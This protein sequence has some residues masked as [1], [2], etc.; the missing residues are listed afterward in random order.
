MSVTLAIG[1]LRYSIEGAPPPPWLQRY[2]VPASPTDRRVQFEVTEDTHPQASTPSGLQGFGYALDS[3]DG[4]DLARI[5]QSGHPAEGFLSA[6]GGIV[7][8]DAPS[9][10]AMV[11]HAGAL[12]IQDGVALVMAPPGT[13]KTTLVRAGGPRAFAHNAVLVRR[14]ESAEMTAWALPFAGDPDPSLDA[15][16][17]AP[18]RVLVELARATRARFEWRTAAQAT[19]RVVKSCAR[20]PGQDPYPSTRAR[21]A[22]EMASLPFGTLFAGAPTDALDA[23]DAALRARGRTS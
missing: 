6:L 12:R 22:L 20:P 4:I 1:P 13:G 21:L 11:I 5:V 18:V 15:P 7:V 10:A 2:A 9:V 23:L 14:A 3:R 19:I 17:T 16:G 8:R